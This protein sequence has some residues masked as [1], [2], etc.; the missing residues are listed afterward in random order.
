MSKIYP[1]D[2]VVKALLQKLGGSTSLKIPELSPDN[3]GR[4]ACFLHIPGLKTQI[5]GDN[6]ILTLEEEP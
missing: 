5:K 3:R 6:L 4:L 1:Q 2:I